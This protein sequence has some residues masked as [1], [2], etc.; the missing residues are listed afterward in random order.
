MLTALVT[1]PESSGT[2]LVSRILRRA[3]AEVCHRSATYGE[4]WQSLRELADTCD[5]VV[6][7]FRDPFSTMASQEA[8]GLD[9][10]PALD[11]LRRGYREIFGSL[12][13]STDRVF[14]V[15]YEQLVL[16]RASIVPLLSHLGLDVN[17]AVA[18]E[19][20]NE[21]TKYASVGRA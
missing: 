11:K 6:I 7:V 15:T 20:T 13:G 14:V 10:K 8:E 19:V 4:R 1:G 5:V 12:L 9:M 16:D 18:E 17:A 3:G 2:S 21:N